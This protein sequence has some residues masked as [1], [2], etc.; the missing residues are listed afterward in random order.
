MHVQHL[1]ETTR[2]PTYNA[3]RITDT[4]HAQNQHIIIGHKVIALF[5]IELF[6]KKVSTF[7]HGNDINLHF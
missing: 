5:G 3:L 6:V 4:L 2:Q 1:I 7:S